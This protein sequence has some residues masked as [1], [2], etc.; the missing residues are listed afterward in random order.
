MGGAVRVAAAPAAVA[1]SARPVRTVSQSEDGVERIF[2][3]V[4]VEIE[5]R[6]DGDAELSV[7][8]EIAQRAPATP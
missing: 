1:I 7:T 5:W 2:Q 4:E 8:L 3:C 6:L